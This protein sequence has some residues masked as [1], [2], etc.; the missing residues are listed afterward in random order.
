MPNQ[1]QILQEVHQ[2]V[3][4]KPNLTITQRNEVVGMSATGLSLK[5]IAQYFG[6]TTQGIGKILK[7]YNTTHTVE[8]KPRSGRP[9]ILSRHQKKLIYRAARA[10][11]KVEYKQLA[12]VGVLVNLDGTTSKP[13]SRSTLY[14]V[15]KGQGVR[16]FP[17]KKRP[18][19]TRGHALASA[20]KVLPYLDKLSMA[21]A[22]AQVLRRVYY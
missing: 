8:D 4:R 15:L 17:C 12:E 14:R 9:P 3:R 10:A 16:N 1:R 18:K 20:P 13:P 7:K 19:L 6:R 5:E 22:H 11:P 21:S 2:N